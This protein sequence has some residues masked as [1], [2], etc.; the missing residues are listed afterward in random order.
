MAVSGKVFP[1]WAYAALV[2]EDHSVGEKVWGS[3]GGIPWGEPP[4]PDGGGRPGEVRGK[5]S[6]WFHMR[7][8][9]QNLPLINRNH[10]PKTIQIRGNPWKSVYYVRY[11]RCVLYVRGT[12]PTSTGC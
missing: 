9:I 11:V 5:V 6:E 2:P 4:A 7:R 10:Y 3:F 1:F 12:F 8:H